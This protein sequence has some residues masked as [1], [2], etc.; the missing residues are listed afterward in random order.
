MIIGILLDGSHKPE[1]QHLLEKCSI[2]VHAVHFSEIT[3]AQPACE[4]AKHQAVLKNL[5][6]AENAAAFCAH[7]PG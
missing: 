3:A 7:L 4:N 1:S 5:M 2:Q 6:L